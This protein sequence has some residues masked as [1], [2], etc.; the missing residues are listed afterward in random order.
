MKNLSTL[1]WIVLIL[2]VI[3]SINWG[4]VGFFNFNLVDIIF[5]TVPV[6][7]RILYAVVGLCGLYLIFRL[8]KKD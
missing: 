7:A 3:G 5:H 2:V 4:L 1:D 8:A 6:I